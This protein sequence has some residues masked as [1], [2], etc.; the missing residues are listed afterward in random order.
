MQDLK[1]GI[2]LIRNLSL[3]TNTLC[4]LFIDGNIEEGLPRLL[5][6]SEDIVVLMEWL[7]LMELE[8]EETI[9][10]LN[11][12]LKSLIE[13]IERE[14]YDFIT[15]FLMNEIKLILNYWEKTLND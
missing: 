10:E 3:R 8:K 13:S 5:M 9:I 6:F 1:L 2:D 12:K 14:D 11:F 7:L 4:Q 15:D